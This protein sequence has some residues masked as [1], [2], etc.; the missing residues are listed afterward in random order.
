M[1]N[2]FRAVNQFFFV[3]ILRVVHQKCVSPAAVTPRTHLAN[4]LCQPRTA[5][6]VKNNNL[7]QM[8]KKENFPRRAPRFCPFGSFVASE[9]FAAE[10]KWSFP[11]WKMTTGIFKLKTARWFVIWPYAGLRVLHCVLAS[12]G[13]EKGKKSSL[14]SQFFFFFASNFFHFRFSGNDFLWFFALAKDE[15]SWT[16]RLGCTQSQFF[17]RHWTLCKKDVKKWKK[18]SQKNCNLASFACNF[19]FVNCVK[20]W[21]NFF[22]TFSL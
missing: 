5:S 15:N 7:K 11:E 20:E 4:A 13:E 1:A 3:S 12:F 6:E 21:T 18:N 9:I 22:D 14:V 17:P 16:F 8:N 2:K 10:R 19:S